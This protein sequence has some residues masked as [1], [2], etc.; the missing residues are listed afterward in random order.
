MPVQSELC[1][2]PGVEELHS[3]KS[4]AALIDPVSLRMR[5]AD[6]SVVADLQLS[7]E[8]LAILE[9]SGPDFGS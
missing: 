3:L 4:P 2:V 5:K 1:A 6:F 8:T 9:L 7:R